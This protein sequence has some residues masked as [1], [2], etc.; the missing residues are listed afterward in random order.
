MEASSEGHKKPGKVKQLSASLGI[1]LSAFMPGARPPMSRKAT[2]SD[3][4]S[5]ELTT[6]ELNHVSFNI[7][8][9][10]VHTVY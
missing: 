7:A 6:D 8:L 10:L 4:L 5:N 1:N 3:E 2:M 9:I